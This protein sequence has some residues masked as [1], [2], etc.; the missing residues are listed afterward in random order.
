MDTY[1]EENFNDLIEL[2]KSI[3]VKMYS[4]LLHIGDFNLG[5]IN[6]TNCSTSIGEEHI[7]TKLLECVRGNYIFQHV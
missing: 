5:E 3:T 1:T 7:A 6:W 2:F 4:H